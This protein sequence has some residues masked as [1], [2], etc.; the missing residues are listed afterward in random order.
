MGLLM[1]YK[2]CICIKEAIANR[3]NECIKLLTYI[4]KIHLESDIAWSIKID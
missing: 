2:I 4:N 3:C 1:V